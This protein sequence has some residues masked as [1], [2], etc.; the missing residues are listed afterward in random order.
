M[1]E[2]MTLTVKWSGKEY[3]VTVCGDDTVGELKRSIFE[4]TNVLPKRQKLLYPKV[5]SKLSDDSL[6]LSQL[7]LKPSIKMTMMGSAFFSH[8]IA[9]LFCL[10]FWS[11]IFFLYMKFEL[12]L[13]RVLKTISVTR[14]NPAFI[15]IIII[16][17]FKVCWGFWRIVL[18]FTPFCLGSKLDVTCYLCVHT[19]LLGEDWGSGSHGCHIS[20]FYLWLLWLIFHVDAFVCICKTLRNLDGFD[21]HIFLWDWFVFLLNRCD[22][23]LSCWQYGLTRIRGTHSRI[24]E[25]LSFSYY[26]N[27][28]I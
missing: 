10:C 27:I 19:S 22:K 5:G 12:Y 25:C 18:I 26:P 16:L 13:I 20:L 11:R 2:E 8:S 24:R 9:L 28:F 14:F 6:L 7:S 23:Y 21:L 15:I 3:T 4:V 17:S 1:E